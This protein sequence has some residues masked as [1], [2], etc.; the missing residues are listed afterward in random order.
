MSKLDETIERELETMEEA[1][2]RGLVTATTESERELQE[3][4]LAVAREAPE[5]EPAFSSELS[6]RVREGFPRERRASRF[7]VPPMPRLRRPPMIALAGLASVVAALA[8]ALPLLSGGKDPEMSTS[9]AGGGAGQPPAPESELSAPRDQSGK[10]FRKL[11]GK[12]AAGGGVADDALVPNA[13]QTRD[14]G[15]GYAEF[16]PG[17]PE[18]RIERSAALTI[19]APD[20]KLDRVADQIVT[21]T[22]RYEGFVLRSNVS[23]GDAGLPGGEFQLRIPADRLQAALRDLSKLGDVRSRTQAGDDVTRSF[24]SAGD[25]LEGARAERRSLLRRLESAETDTQAE[26]IRSRLDFNASEI[27]GLRG[28]L[29]DLRLRTHY[30]KVSV[31]LAQSSG[32]D[33]EDGAANGDGI[34]GA[35]DD[36]LGSLS[37]SVEMLVRALGVLVPLAVLAALLWLGGSAVRRRRREGAL[38]M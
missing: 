25:R 2:E 27:S 32:A 12:A 30:A 8:V 14:R 24:V 22:D 26:S 21:V 33:D 1:V 38:S 7:S 20:A 11:E 18:R 17:A 34:G 3:I 37:D 5:P 19:E 15:Q 6:E 16:A 36:A 35:L 28:R 10:G 29:R 23:S 4:A 9:S 31:T 13:L